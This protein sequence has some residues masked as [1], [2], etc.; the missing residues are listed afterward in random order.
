M[1]NKKLIRKHLVTIRLN[2][3]EYFEVIDRCKRLNISI[4]DY[5]RLVSLSFITGGNSYENK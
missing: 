4:S 1:K 5:F 3:S 2:D